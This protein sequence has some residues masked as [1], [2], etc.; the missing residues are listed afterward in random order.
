MTA[1]YADEDYDSNHHMA[2]NGAGGSVFNRVYQ[3]VHSAIN[4][5]TADN[6]GQMPSEASQIT[7]Y[8]QRPIDAA[9][10]EKYRQQ[11]A[12]QHPS[13]ESVTVAPLFEAYAKAHNEEGPKAPSDL[14][15]YATTS[16]QRA[17]L[18]KLI[19]PD[20]SSSK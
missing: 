7:P 19:K 14:L 10:I 13:P 5:F 4:A 2:I 18:E 12:A 6:N 8:L 3:A 11:Y 1:P 17:V 15:P 16:Q 20:S 9:T